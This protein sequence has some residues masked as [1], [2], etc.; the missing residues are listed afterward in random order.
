MPDG[1]CLCGKIRYRLDGP[2]L[3]AGFCHCTICRRAAGAPVVAWGTWRV[4]ALSWLRGEPRRHDSSAKGRRWFCADCG[5]QLAFAHADGP[6]LIDVTLASLDD[7]DA[8]KPEY[9]V[10]VETRIGWMETA[11]RLPRHRD[12]GPDVEQMAELGGS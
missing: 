8:V 2:P 9:H 5:S 7:P 1:G 6:A 4:E 3:D 12:G 10:W 11:D